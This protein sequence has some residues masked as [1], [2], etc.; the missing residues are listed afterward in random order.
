[1]IGLRFAILAAIALAA[2]LV[3]SAAFASDGARPVPPRLPFAVADAEVT[4]AVV[5]Q[6]DGRVAAVDLSSGH[7]RWRSPHG[8]WPLAS[9]HGWVAV[10]APDSAD[11][12]TLRVRF[13]R[14]TDGKLIVTSAPIALP[15]VI[16]ANASWEGEG[17]TLGTGD[18]SV[19]LWA[20]IP[21]PKTSG[22]SRAERLHVR[23]RTQSFIGGG[24]MRPPE[25][26]PVSSG[27]AFVDP[28]SGAVS[29]GPDDPAQGPEP[30]PPKLPPSWKRSP[31]T[32]YWSWSWFGAAWSDAP[33]AFWIGPG[34]AGFF[35]YETARRR[36]LL[37]R[38]GPVEPVSPFEIAA[39]GEW[40]PQVSL[41]GRHL[42]LSK[43][44]A[45]VETF[46][47]FD[48]LRPG[49]A[50][51]ISIPHLEPRFRS[52]FAVVGPS[53]YYVA[54]GDGVSGTSGA[55][56]F[57]RWLVCVDWA[58]GRIRWSHAL[59]PRALPPPM[60]GAGPGSVGAMVATRADSGAVPAAECPAQEP[61]EG[62]SC[63][64][65][66]L[67]CTYADSPSCGSIWACYAG[68][69]RVLARGSCNHRDVCPA[70]AEAPMPVIGA[71]AALS[72]TCVYAEGLACTYRFDPPPCSGVA[73]P[74]PTKHQAR[75]RCER[76]GPT[77]C[78][79][80]V[81]AGERCVEEGLTC[82][83]GCCSAGRRCVKG[84]WTEFFSPCPP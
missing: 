46:T 52:P 4:V 25:R 50:A 45:G 26:G 11:P 79:V 82:G 40:A 57:P 58:G 10:G 30:Q 62:A 74:P 49:S 6:S 31:G 28:T 21:R 84:T 55:T 66:E 8:R 61:A 1:M 76:P 68:K 43:G 2:L 39:G 9:G 18:T 33:R 5:A 78:I 15:A 80:S 54:E 42:L 37:N 70:T 77:G 20:W 75:W 47:L 59:P 27:L 60:A 22:D 17:L 73:R 67:R 36:L 29:A 14:P 7:V 72:M 64:S 65:R 35:S 48:L 16:G 69:W 63:R 81:R 38:F 3:P 83:G 13:L 41:D 23:W 56:T 34:L 12:R 71:R 19:Q 24:G 44:N 32:I 51:A 53:L